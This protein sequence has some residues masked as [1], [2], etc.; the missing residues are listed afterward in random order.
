MPKV[1]FR[2]ASAYCEW[3]FSVR[4]RARCPRRLNA[5]IFLTIACDAWRGPNR[6]FGLVVPT[7]AQAFL[8]G[9][10][11][12]AG[13]LRLLRAALRHRRAQQLLLSA[14]AARA[15][16][17]L[18][19]AGATRLSLCRQGQSLRHPHQAAGRRTE[20]HRVGR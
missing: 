3:V 18:A 9:E 12:G 19:R 14:A 4:A 11:A 16:R 10:D 5:L 1:S 6:L 2:M 7:L 8:S 17:K 13:A 20:V 15:F